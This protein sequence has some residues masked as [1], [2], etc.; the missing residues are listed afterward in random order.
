MKRRQ[1]N[2]SPSPCASHIIF[3]FFPMLDSMLD[4]LNIFYSDTVNSHNMLSPLGVL[5]SRDVFKFRNF[6]DTP[7]ICSV[8][9]Y[10]YYQMLLTPVLCLT[11]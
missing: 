10:A 3:D 5:N 9:L 1:I 7:L 11:L 6:Y 4:A 8:I 2:K